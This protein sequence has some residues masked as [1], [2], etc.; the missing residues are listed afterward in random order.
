MKEAGSVNFSSFS[1]WA[2]HCKERALPL[3]AAVLDYEV[4]EKSTTEE[5]IWEGVASVCRAM[6]EAIEEGLTGEM[7]SRSGMVDNSG[8]KV[9]NHPVAVLSHEFQRLVGYALSAKEVNACMGRVVAAPTAGA[10][11]ILP[12]VLRLLKEVHRVRER[13]LH[14]AVLVAAG[15]GLIIKNRSSISGA[16]GGC[17][18]ETGSAAAMGAGAIVYALGGGVTE[19]FHAVAVAIQCT[20]GLICDPVAGL[21]EVP[22]IVRNASAAAIA[23]SSAQIA[24]CKVDSVIPVD[25]CLDVMKEVGDAMEPRFKETAK[26]GLANTKTGR[27][28]LKNLFKG[29]TEDTAFPAP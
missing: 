9:Y 12:A 14:E 15:I 26:G 25:E 1:G 20:L 27:Q 11:G 24:L 17:Q 23:Y 8:K 16:M 5:A 3:H 4:A 13:K 21:V 29:D 2:S 18:A 6:D 22:C 19:V 7:R 28:I 10:S